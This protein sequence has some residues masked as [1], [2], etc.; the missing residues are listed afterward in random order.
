MTTLSDIREL[1]TRLHS[2]FLEWSDIPLQNELLYFLDEVQE[3]HNDLD[4]RDIPNTGTDGLELDLRHRV[5]L[6]ASGQ[7]AKQTHLDLENK[8]VEVEPRQILL[9]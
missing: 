7:I 6:L 2:H 4:K 1:E 8:P 5:F 3:L 9:L